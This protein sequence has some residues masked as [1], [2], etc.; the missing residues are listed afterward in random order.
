V[1]SLNQMSLPRHLDTCL[2]RPITGVYMGTKSG[3]QEMLISPDLVWSTRKDNNQIQILSINYMSMTILVPI[4][5]HVTNLTH[6][7]NH[8]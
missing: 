4:Y 1:N 6:P 8:N 3:L 2:Y 7:L 5:N